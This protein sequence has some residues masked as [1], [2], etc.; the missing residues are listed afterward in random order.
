MKNNQEEKL[1]SNKFIQE[2]L[3]NESEVSQ[4]NKHKF[5][6]IAPSLAY[7]LKSFSTS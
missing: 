2:F 7:Y 4:K 3:D 1:F 6:E 5:A